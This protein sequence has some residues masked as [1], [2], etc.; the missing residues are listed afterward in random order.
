MNKLKAIVLIYVLCNVTGCGTCSDCEYFEV[1]FPK[2]ANE[3]EVMVRLVAITKYT[4]G[5]NEGSY[6]RFIDIDYGNIEELYISH[7][8][9]GFV[10]GDCN[11]PVRIE[12][13]FLDDPE[14]CLIFDGPI[15][16]DGIDMRS[17]KSYK[18]GR[19][20]E[21]QLDFGVAIEYIY[22]ITPQHRA[23]AKEEFCP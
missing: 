8:D 12:L 15:E 22:T 4:S 10:N 7:N 3:S 5:G 21:G 19:V 14:K 13:H 17:W 6:E 18:R 16:H 20:I 1:E 2:Y 9:C 23:M 11:N